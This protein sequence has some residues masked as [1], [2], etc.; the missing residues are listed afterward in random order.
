MKKHWKDYALLLSV[1]G[2]IVAV[3]QWTKILV[4]SSLGFQETWVPW[5]W[6]SPF[7]RIVH[8][9]NTGAAFGMFQNMNPVFMVLATIVSLAILFYFPRVPRS[10]WYLRLALCLQLAGAVGNLIDRI[11]QGYVTDFI[12]VGTFA[13]FNVADASISTGVAVMLL[14]LWL[15]ERQDKTQAVAEIPAEAAAEF[16]AAEYAAAEHAVTEQPR[17]EESSLE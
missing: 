13:V 8:W 16:A 7:A 6:L 1:A 15:K 11:H 14:G 3:D 2:A 17:A 9:Q 10:E 4:R 12:S 5:D